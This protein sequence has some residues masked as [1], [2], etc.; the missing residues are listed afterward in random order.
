[1]MPA[2]VEHLEAFGGKAG[3]FFER[4]ID[5]H[6][7]DAAQLQAEHQ[8]VGDFIIE[9]TRRRRQP[10]AADDAAVEQDG[11]GPGE[12]QRLCRRTVG[13]ER[14]RRRVHAGVEGAAGLHQ[15]LLGLEHHRRL[16]AVEPAH[17]YQRA[18]ASL[19]C[20][21]LGAA[22][23]IAKLAQADGAEARRQI[24]RLMLGVRSHMSLV[25]K[26]LARPATAPRSKAA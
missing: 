12:L 6:L 3:A 1:M 26:G 23:R 5:G 7:D 20:D 10:A 13:G 17:P 4:M 15:W 25:Y 16:D 14:V 19:G 24:Q 11:I 9:R 18:G 21:R 8:P 2:A 22:E